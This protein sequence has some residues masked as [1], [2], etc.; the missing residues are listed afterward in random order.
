[1]ELRAG[2][3]KT[4][5]GV[6]P[7]EWRTES[8]GSL[9]TLMTNGFVGTATSAY[10]SS[11]DGVLYVQGYNVEPNGFNFHGIKRVNR[12]FHKLHQKSC[13]KKGDLLTIQT[14]DIGVTTLVPPEL[15]G[16]NCH[17]LVI[18]R[19]DPKRSQSE[20]YCHYFNSEIGRAAF[21][22]IETG[23]TMKHLNVGD[24]VQ[25][26]VPSPPLAEQCAI[27]TALS[28]VDALL[29]KIDQLI[30]KKR[31]LKQAAMQ[32]LLTGQTRLPGFSGEWEVKQL[33]DVA[34]VDPENLSNSTSQQYGFKYISLEDV[35]VGTL[36]GFS[37]QVFATAPSRARR[38]LRLGDVLI[39]TVRPN[40]MSH[41]LLKDV[42]TDWVCS[43]GFAVVRCHKETA[44]SGFVFAHLFGRSIARQIET[45]VT[46]SNY[47]AIN[48]RDV[49]AFEIAMPSY[50]EQSAIA[51]VLSDMDAELSALEARRNKT[52]AL[53]QGLMQELLTGKIRL[54]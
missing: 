11:D 40:L 46:G 31:D 33:G 29:A 49:R 28:N 47:P 5:V 10:V 26:L 17:A 13:L 3:K 22:E 8:L 39:S 37:E 54:K 51:T 32:R 12:N 53:K 38:R 34:D 27:A 23:T 9:T 6:I 30:A 50:A 43:T 44:H 19:F 4:E 35:D 14:G 21:K 45:L 25:L 20:F 41:L 16:A 36:R 24:M 18:S 15:E 2:Y 52:R 42:G 7:E 1:M 48:S